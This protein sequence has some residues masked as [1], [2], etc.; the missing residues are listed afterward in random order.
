MTAL[1]RHIY[2]AV[3]QKLHNFNPNFD[4]LLF[5]LNIYWHTGYSYRKQHSETVANPITDRVRCKA[6]MLIGQNVLTVH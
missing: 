3:Y 6:T 2:L 4:F 1:C 5:E